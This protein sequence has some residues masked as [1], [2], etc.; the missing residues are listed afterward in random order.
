MQGTWRCRLG[1]GCL[2]NEKVVEWRSAQRTSAMARGRNERI[3]KNRM[4]IGFANGK[5]G[6]LEPMVQR[7]GRGDLCLDRQ[8]SRYI[9]NMLQLINPPG[10]PANKPGSTRKRQ[11]SIPALYNPIRSP[12]PTSSLSL[13]L[14]PFLSPSCRLQSCATSPQS[15]K[16]HL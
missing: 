14:C 10:Y 3:E 4:G 9:L 8:C 13:C 12:L 16:P 11:T 15:D 2:G 6:I 1:G 5:D 7:M